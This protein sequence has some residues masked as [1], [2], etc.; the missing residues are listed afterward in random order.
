[1]RRHDTRP[2]VVRP[3]F[4][5]SFNPEWLDQQLRAASERGSIQRV[6]G[7]LADGARV[8]RHVDKHGFTALHAAT[9]GGSGDVVD[10]L[11]QHEP[12][13]ADMT[14]SWWKKTCL[15]FASWQGTARLSVL[16][17]LFVTSYLLTCGTGNKRIVCSLLKAQA[18][19][20]AKDVVQGGCVCLFCFL[21]GREA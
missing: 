18:N 4:P 10:I 7:L 1:M 11:L 2:S 14:E 17:Q 3:A 12:Q 16:A 8:G 6:N 5:A 20:N 19:G 21:R 9:L 15:H 13:C